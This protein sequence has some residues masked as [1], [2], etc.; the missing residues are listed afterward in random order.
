MLP[1]ELHVQGGAPLRRD[2]QRQGD[3]PVQVKFI[4]SCN[5]HASQEAGMV[6]PVC[7]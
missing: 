5:I 1:V 4:L 6:G 7:R 3:F 2:G